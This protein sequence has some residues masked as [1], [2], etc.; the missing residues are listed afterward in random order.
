MDQ[1]GLQQDPRSQI[2]KKKKKEAAAAAAAVDA[3]MQAKPD[4]VTFSTMQLAR[5]FKVFLC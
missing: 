4:I 5:V 1:F 2:R 3:C